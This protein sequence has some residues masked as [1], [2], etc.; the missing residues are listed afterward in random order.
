[1]MLEMMDIFHHFANLNLI[2]V[3]TELYRAYP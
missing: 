1:M 2:N 3:N